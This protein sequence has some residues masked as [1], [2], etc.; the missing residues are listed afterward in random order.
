[1]RAA[2][3]GW[4]LLPWTNNSRPAHN[5]R[6]RT[7]AALPSSR[8]GLEGILDGEGV[9]SD[10]VPIELPWPLSAPAEALVVSE[11]TRQ[12]PERGWAGPGRS[13]LLRCSTCTGDVGDACR[14][15][16][17]VARLPIVI[18]ALGGP[19]PR[20]QA[21]AAPAGLALSTEGL[22]KGL[23]IPGELLRDSLTLTPSA[24]ALGW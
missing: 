3:R 13:V 17:T 16:F 8:S 22:G 1:M 19:R 7:L 2:F 15:L 23:G 18:A 12:C 21:A 9:P 11:S 10:A 6:W 5:C 24:L 4:L 20:S 14:G